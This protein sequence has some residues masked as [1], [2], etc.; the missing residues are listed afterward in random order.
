MARMHRLLCLAGGLMVGALGCRV[1]AQAPTGAT[2]KPPVTDP[3]FTPGGVY[4]QH[5]LKRPQPRVVTPGRDAMVIGPPSDAVVL[6]GGTDLSAWDQDQRQPDGKTTQRVS[7]PNWPIR[8]G[9]FE[10]KPR[11]GS[12]VSRAR[13]GDC[14]I[15]LEWATPQQVVGNSQGRGNSGLFIAGHPEIQLL[16]SYQNPTYPDGQAGALYGLYPPLV[17]ASRPPGEWQVYDVLYRA[18]RLNAAGRKT[19]SATYTVF[20]NGVVVQNCVAVPGEAAQS[21]IGLQDH[22]NP[23]RFRNIW[24]RPLG[25]YDQTRP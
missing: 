13:F 24:V 11:S 2:P 23:M 14:Q 5:D 21:T 9:Y 25:E 8:D 6:F 16:D 22:N 10:V 12:I 1:V 19:D 20:H 7:P 17:N 4:R 18:P 3:P 15:H